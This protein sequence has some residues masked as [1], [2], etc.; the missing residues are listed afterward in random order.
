[1]HGYYECDYIIQQCI[2]IGVLISPQTYCVVVNR[3]IFTIEWKSA[4]KT[5]EMTSILLKSPVRY[6][7]NYINVL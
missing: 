1:M 3:S 2:Q 5:M 7:P 4:Y 6:I